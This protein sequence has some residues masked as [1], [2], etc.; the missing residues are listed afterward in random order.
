[1]A[2]P[3]AQI[4]SDTK[5]SERQILDFFNSQVA[6]Q[7]PDLLI[8]V[9]DYWLSQIQYKIP[10]TFSKQ[11]KM[12]TYDDNLK[13]IL[14]YVLERNRRLFLRDIQSFKRWIEFLNYLHLGKPA[15]GEQ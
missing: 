10:T 11:A 13:L 3:A 14:V 7:S 2:K 5:K 9:C 15:E 1:V 8:D 6:N 12:Q 4:Q